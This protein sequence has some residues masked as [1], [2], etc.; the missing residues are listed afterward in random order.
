MS[1]LEKFVDLDV[2]DTFGKMSQFEKQQ[3]IKKFMGNRTIDWLVCLNDLVE[4]FGNHDDFRKCSISNP[5]GMNNCTIA[6]FLIFV[7]HAKYN[8]YNLWYC[9]TKFPSFAVDIEKVKTEHKIIGLPTVYVV[10]LAKHRELTLDNFIKAMDAACCGQESNELI[11]FATNTTISFN[12]LWQLVPKVDSVEV[13]GK[14]LA[15]GQKDKI[16]KFRYPAF[17]SKECHD[18]CNKFAGN[19]DWF[20]EFEDEITLT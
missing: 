17:I 20:P 14:L 1:Q 9:L 18:L 4:S 13:V 2:L 10:V 16:T 7:C 6:E 8:T 12:D 19:P 5:L 3:F 15:L 11:E